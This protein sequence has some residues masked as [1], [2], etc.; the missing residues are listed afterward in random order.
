L[1]ITAPD[2]RP[3]PLGLGLDAYALALVAYLLLRRVAGDSFW[4]VFLAGYAASLASMA[5][6]ILIPVA[7]AR[8]QWVTA[9]AMCVGFAAFATQYSGQLGWRIDPGESPRLRVVTC[10]AGNGRAQPDLLV[11][12]IAQSGADIVGLVEVSGA[13]RRALE[14]GLGV[15]YPYQLHI[16]VG[17]AGKALLSRY[18]I[19]SWE[20]LEYNPGRP[21]LVAQVDVPDHVLRVVVAHPP[22][23]RI[24]STGVHFTDVVAAQY[25]SLLEKLATGEPTVLIGDLNITPQHQ[26][27]DRLRA[28]GLIDSFAEAGTGSGFTFARR[29]AGIPTPPMIRIDY[30]WHSPQLKAAGAWVGPDVGSDHLPVVADLTWIAEGK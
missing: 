27:Y 6:I 14:D 17:T 11:Q 5:S 4:P 26:R 7:L 1:R 3:G 20:A 19:A 25:A 16:G 28:A 10:N 22:P 15:T 9:A 24:Q 29:V 2:G 13:Q 12:A 8:R 18:A 23:P 30:V 21:D